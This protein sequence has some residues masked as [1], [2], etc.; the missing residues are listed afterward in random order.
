MGRLPRWSRRLLEIGALPS[1]SDELRVRKAVLVL[2][3]TL[4]ASLAFVWVGTYASLGLWVSAAIPFTYQVASAISIYTFARTR[5]YLLFRWSQLCM[6]LVLPFALQWSL[7]G[8]EA[9]S[10]VC[11][12]AITSPFGALLFVGAR[13]AVPWFAA[14]LG[15]V[16]VSAL[17]DPVLADRAADIPDGVQVTFFAL[18]IL[19][20]AAT[21]Y[22]LLQYFVR[23][24]ERALAELARQHH[25]LELEQAKSER[26]LLNVL[27]EPVAARLKNEEGIIADDHPD[28]TVLFAD[29]VGFTPLSERLSAPELV[30]L[31][32]RVFARWDDVAADHGVEKIKTIGDA[33]MVAGGVPI[34]RDDHADAIAEMGLAMGPELARCSAEAGLPLQIRIGIDTGA[35]VA[36][37]IGRAKFIY[38]VW[39]DTVNTAS[40]MESLAPPGTIQVTERT[41]ERLRHRYEF[42]QRGT[43]EV[44]GKGLM[45]CYLLLRRRSGL[46]AQARREFVSG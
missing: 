17:I 32:D 42:S 1:D 19:G 34:P 36:G 33:Y 26:L 29:I 35:V 7:G 40:R 38:D 41:Y 28:V 18:N 45:T 4:M 10:A 6:S 23:A 13:Q 39:G 30:S 15:L 8:F 44:K 20:A 9:S 43:I 27:P 3:S 37:V 2:S 12:W 14:F 46:T 24:R 16:V 5:R 25:A 31:L 21:A 11:L 22:A